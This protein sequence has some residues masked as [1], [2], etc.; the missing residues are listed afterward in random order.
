MFIIKN[1]FFTEIMLKNYKKHYYYLN[2]PGETIVVLYIFNH[3]INKSK[4]SI[5]L[6]YFLPLYMLLFSRFLFLLAQPWRLAFRPPA[7]AP[8]GKV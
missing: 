8:P 5:I 6:T 3:K 7:T 1:N 4:Y 2:E